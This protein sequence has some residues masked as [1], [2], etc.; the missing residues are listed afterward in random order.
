MGKLK[1]N[2]FDREFE[3]LNTSEKKTGLLVHHIEA[4]KTT[5]LFNSNRPSFDFDVH[6]LV[7][8]PNNEFSL[9]G[10]EEMAQS[11]EDYGQLQEIVVIRNDSNNYMIVV[12]HRRTYAVR[13]IYNKYD[14]LFKET[15]NKAYLMKRDMYSTIRGRILETFESDLAEAIYLESN[16]EHRQNTFILALNHIPHLLKKLKDNNDVEYLKR[17]YGNDNV[18]SKINY[19]KT[20]FTILSEKLRVSDVSETTINR[21]L[22]ILNKSNSSLI[23]AVKSGKITVTTAWELSRKF[24]LEEQDALVNAFGTNDYDVLLSSFTLNMNKSTNKDTSDRVKLSA[25]EKSFLSKIK[26][27]DKASK[28]KAIFNELR[29]LLLEV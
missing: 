5:E 14:A 22:S 2:A 9:I 15:G 11:I 10:I 6:T 13:F 17:L 3:Q 28:A 29:S 19:S 24:T 20:I 18:P 8:W 1:T 7:D 16:Y 26:D 23:S 21:Y 12:G 25:F 27:Q 4:V